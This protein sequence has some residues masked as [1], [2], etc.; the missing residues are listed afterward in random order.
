MIPL[1]R[2]AKWRILNFL[3]TL[4]LVGWIGFLYMRCIHYAA[5]AP[6]TYDATT[7]HIYEVNNHGSYFYLDATQNLRTYYPLVL[8]AASLLTTFLLQK[9]WK[10]FKDSAD[11]QAHKRKYDSMHH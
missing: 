2:N 11:I 8:V 5:V 9:R 4:A 1:S 7:G 6:A 3:A 10:V